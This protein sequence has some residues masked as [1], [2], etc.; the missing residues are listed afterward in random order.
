LFW[1]PGYDTVVPQDLN[2]DGKIDIVLYNSTTGTEY[3]GLSNGSGGFSYSYSL[4]GPGK[5]LAR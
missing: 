2:G 1:S 5:A 4:W 3:S